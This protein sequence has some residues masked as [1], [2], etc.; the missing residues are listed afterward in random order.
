M[1]V[2]VAAAEVDHP[3]LH[4]VVAWSQRILAVVAAAAA[5][6]VV[7]VAAET[8]TLLLPLLSMIVN[9]MRMRIMPRAFETVPP[10]AGAAGVKLVQRFLAA[11][12]VA[13]QIPV[14][15]ELLVEVVVLLRKEIVAAAAAAAAKRMAG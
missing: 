3:A 6:A 12:A 8:L 10:V 14:P 5:A 1:F 4:G 15:V 13:V 2:V 7:A 11:A 9:G